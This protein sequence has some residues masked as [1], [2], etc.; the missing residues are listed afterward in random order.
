MR[1]IDVFG[2]PIAGLFAAGET[3]G[4]FH[5]AG[6]YSGSSLSSSATFGMLAGRAAAAYPA[7]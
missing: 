2:E 7:T 6:Y 3:V 1:V 4:G 5:G